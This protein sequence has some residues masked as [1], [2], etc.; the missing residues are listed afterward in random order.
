MHSQK[1][2]DKQTLLIKNTF[3]DTYVCIQIM[4]AFFVHLFQIIQINM[5]SNQR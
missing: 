3:L 1:S 2:F 4:K 5:E